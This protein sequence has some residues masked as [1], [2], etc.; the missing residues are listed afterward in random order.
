MLEEDASSSNT[1]LDGIGAEVIT[2]H[3]DG[4][5]H[6]KEDLLISNLKPILN[7]KHFKDVV[8]NSQD[9]RNSLRGAFLAQVR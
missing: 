1:N 9:V 5:A 7:V 3:F 4:V 6:S 8:V 2:V